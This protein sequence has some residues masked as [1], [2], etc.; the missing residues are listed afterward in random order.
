MMA[1]SICYAQT[2]ASGNEQH[3]VLKSPYLLEKTFFFLIK[4]LHLVL[5]RVYLSPAN[6]ETELRTPSYD[7]LRTSWCHT[8]ISQALN[9]ELTG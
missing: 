9:S 2:S 3:G 6:Y 1:D 5:V 4:T 7:K 8:I